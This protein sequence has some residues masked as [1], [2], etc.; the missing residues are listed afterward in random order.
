MAQNFKIAVAGI[1]EVGGYYG[2]KL[3]SIYHGSPML[4]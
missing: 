3:A 2:G 4:R 1:G